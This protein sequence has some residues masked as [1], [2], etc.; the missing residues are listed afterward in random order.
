MNPVEEVL[1]KSMPQVSGRSRETSDPNPWGRRNAPSFARSLRWR[2]LLPTLFVSTLL[3]STLLVS[4]LLVSTLLALALGAGSAL[5][6]VIDAPVDAYFDAATSAGWKQGYRVVGTYTPPTWSW[7]KVELLEGYQKF[8]TE[9]YNLRTQK[10]RWQDTFEDPTLDMDNNGEPDYPVRT[11]FGALNQQLVDAFNVYY[12]N[13]CVGTVGSTSAA[14]CP[15]PGPT[16]PQARFALLHYGPLTAKGQCDTTKAPVL[17]VHGAMQNANVWLY[18]GGNDGQGNA[19]PGVTQT[20]GLVQELEK[21]NYCTFAITL[22]NFHGDNYAHAI[23]VANA[24]ARIKTVIK[25]SLAKVNVVAW[26][27]GVLPVDLYAGNAAKWTDYSTAYFDTIAKEQAKWVPAFRKDIRTYV[28]L[29][30][31]HLGIDL[32]FRHPYNDLLIF[33]TAEN[34][35]LGEGPVTW[36]YTAAMQCV[37]WGLSDSPE[38]WYPNFYAYSVCEGRGG[39]WTDYWNRIYASNITGLDSQG[40]PLWTKTLKDLNVTEGVSASTFS[41]DQYN[42]AM[43]GSVNDAGKYVTPYLGQLQASYNLLEFYDVRHPRYDNPACTDD[44]RTTDWEEIDTEVTYWYPWME[45]KTEYYP[46][47][48]YTGGG[49]LDDTAWDQCRYTAYTPSKACTAHHI[50]YNARNAESY[51]LGYATYKLFD[52]LGIDAVTAMGGN[53]IKRIRTK[54][55]STDMDFLYVLYG[56]SSGTPGTVFETDGLQCPSSTNAKGDG[57]LFDVSIDGRYLVQ[58][59]SSSIKSSKFKSEGMPFGHLDIGVSPDAWA[60]ILARF[61]AL[62]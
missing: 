37:T 8:R 54:S 23:H 17:L 32:N 14:A 57:V 55:L 41:F 39:V 25:R 31:P 5:A 21:N 22:G 29:S 47:Y 33:S 12:K 1:L 46:V 11:Y 16:R 61:Q 49:W 26:S 56:T 38:D 62:P 50:Y 59:W 42:I 40:R 28:A 24:M 7:G 18:P 45:L 19:Y 36:S 30:G 53:F 44:G 15:D 2:T 4:T 9:G 20:T 35:P 6:S 34:A 27:K 43:W 13:T 51:T 48:P 58:G 52:G 3:V 60:K 10:Q